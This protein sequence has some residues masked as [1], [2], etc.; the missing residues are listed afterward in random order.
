[1]RFAAWRIGAVAARKRPD[2]ASLVAG[3]RTASEPLPLCP[4]DHPQLTS[5]GLATLGLIRFTR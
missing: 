4:R 3:K 1:M 2:P 5:F